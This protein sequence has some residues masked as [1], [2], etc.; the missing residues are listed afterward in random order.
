[1]F[2]FGIYKLLPLTHV[3]HVVHVAHVACC[4]IAIINQLTDFDLF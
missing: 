2:V 3:A 1:M 4:E